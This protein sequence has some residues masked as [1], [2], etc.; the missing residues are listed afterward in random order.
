MKLINAF[1]LTLVLMLLIPTVTAKDV[2]ISAVEENLEGVRLTLVRLNGECIFNGSTDGCAKRRGV[3]NVTKEYLRLTIAST[4]S[5]SKVKALKAM[6]DSFD[7]YV[8]VL[9]N[10]MKNVNSTK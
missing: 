7:K 10:T 2:S 9:K 5:E 3:V 8:E 4:S 6:S 1:T